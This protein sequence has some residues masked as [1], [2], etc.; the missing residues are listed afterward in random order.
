MRTLAD[1]QQAIQ[2]DDWPTARAACDELVDHEQPNGRPPAC[3][4]FSIAR[5]A[6]AARLGLGGLFTVQRARRVAV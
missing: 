3:W 5:E 1:L 6:V 4:G 2:A